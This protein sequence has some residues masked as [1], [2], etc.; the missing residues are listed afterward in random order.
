MNKIKVTISTIY[1]LS[2]FIFLTLFVEQS[3]INANTINGIQVPIGASTTIGK[4]SKKKILNNILYIFLFLKL[5][6]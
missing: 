3:V 6:I 5:S 1:F 4:T 2:N